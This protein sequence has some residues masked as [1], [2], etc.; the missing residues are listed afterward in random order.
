MT[1]T[2]PEIAAIRDALAFALAGEVEPS[3]GRNAPRHMREALY[4]LASAHALVPL[5]KG[6][7]AQLLE[8]VGQMT[9]GN[10]RDFDEW[11]K[12]THGSHAQWRALLKGEHKLAQAVK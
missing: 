2:A 6:E 1:I 10:A 4:K 7:A 12:Q 9:D 11:R 5:T 8:A 3:W